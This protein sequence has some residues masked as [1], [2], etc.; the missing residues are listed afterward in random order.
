ML[1]PYVYSSKDITK[2]ITFS[3]I[4]QIQEFSQISSN[5][6]KYVQKIPADKFF[7]LAMF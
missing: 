2:M 3:Q 5:F 4:F 6:T 1:H 7:N